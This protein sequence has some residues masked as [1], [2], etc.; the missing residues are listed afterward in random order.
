MKLCDEVKNKRGT[1]RIYAVST[2]R[3]IGR[4]YKNPVGL[5]HCIDCGKERWVMLY[6]GLPTSIRCAHCAGKLKRKNYGSAHHN[7]KGGVS[8]CVG[9]KIIRL[10]SDDFFYPMTQKL[11]YV[12]EH[13]LVMAKHL[14]RCLQSW[15]IVHHKNHIRTDN[16]IENLQLVSDDR[17]RQITILETRIALLEKRITLLEMD[18]CLLRKQLVIGATI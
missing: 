8:R 6:K 5:V 10:Y 16:R 4:N 17:H 18:N 11:G 9:Y 14:G 15:E 3:T 13:R 1:I 2:G 12:L 7:W